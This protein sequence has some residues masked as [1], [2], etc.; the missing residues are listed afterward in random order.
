M[1]GT[2]FTARSLDGSDPCFKAFG[3]HTQLTDRISMKLL[4]AGKRGG[5]GGAKGERWTLPGRYVQVH[6]VHSDILTQS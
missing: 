2:M 5:G 6:Y 1:A 4:G 3:L